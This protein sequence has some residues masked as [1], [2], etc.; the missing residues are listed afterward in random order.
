M[1]KCDNEMRWYCTRDAGHTGPCAVIEVEPSSPLKGATQ[2]SIRL[3]NLV[4]H[5]PIDGIVWV[6]DEN[7]GDGQTV[8]EDE[9][10]KLLQE[11]YNARF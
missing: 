9:L 5:Q 1:S 8:P 4:V 11:F 3:G 7:A 10:V 2:V 6:Y